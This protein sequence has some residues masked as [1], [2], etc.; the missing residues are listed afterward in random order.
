[1]RKVPVLVGIAVA[2]SMAGTVLAGPASAVSQVPAVKIPARAPSKAACKLPPKTGTG[3]AYF[4]M[5]Y[6][7][8]KTRS[9]ETFVYGGIGGNQNRFDTEEECLDACSGA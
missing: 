2:V 3:K 4:E 6:Y 5:Y 8:S 7:D 9:C 1:M